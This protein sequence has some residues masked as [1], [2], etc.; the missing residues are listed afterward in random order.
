M[1]EFASTYR[2]DEWSYNGPD[3]LSRVYIWSSINDSMVLLNQTNFYPL[4]GEN[5]YIKYSTTFSSRCTYYAVLTLAIE[6]G[7]VCFGQ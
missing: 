1:E 7:T 3:L 2:A 5:G 4:D 6:R